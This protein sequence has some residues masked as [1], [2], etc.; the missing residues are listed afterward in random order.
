MALLVSGSTHGSLIISPSATLRRRDPTILLCHK[1][2]AHAGVENLA[3]HVALTLPKRIYRRDHRVYIA[4]L[5][6]T[7]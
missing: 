1:D 4:F 5:K 6:S 7:M 3:L 2:R